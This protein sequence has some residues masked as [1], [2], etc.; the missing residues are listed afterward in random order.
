MGHSKHL[1][2]WPCS[3]FN[4]NPADLIFGVFFVLLLQ[5]E[6]V[7]AVLVG[8]VLLISKRYTETE[9]LE[10]LSCHLDFY[11]VYLRA[12]FGTRGK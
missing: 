7:R 5:I 6:G 10:E 2:H 11:K 12:D 9:V 4:I 8:Q 1:E 3:E